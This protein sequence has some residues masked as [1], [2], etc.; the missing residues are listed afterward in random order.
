MSGVLPNPIQLPPRLSMDDYVDFIEASIRNSNPIFTARQK[1]I[2][3]RILK[4]FRIPIP[5]RTPGPA[6]RP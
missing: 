3:K 1:S 2:E 4:P 5:H 6:T